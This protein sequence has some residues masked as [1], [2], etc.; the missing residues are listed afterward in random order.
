MFQRVALLLLCL[1]ACGGKRLPTGPGS[2]PDRTDDGWEVASFEDQGLQRSWFDW[3]EHD[4]AEATVETPDAVVVARN[5][6]LVYERYWNGFAREEAHD[7]RSATKSLTSLL[8][9]M[10]HERGIL[11]DLDAPVLSLLPH[12]LPVRNPDPRKERITLRHLLQMRTGLACD[13][14]NPDSPGNEERM[15]DT[16]DWVR[17]IVDVPMQDEPGTVTRYCTGG[18]VLLG[19]ALEHASGR[20]VADL[21]REWLFAP[22]KVQDFTW[23][24]AGK[25]GTDTGGHLRLRPRDFLKTGQVVLEGG[26]WQGER[27]VS[28][29][30]VAESG[31][32]LGALGDAGY[33]LLWWSTRFVIQGVPVEV[34]FAR[35]N[36]GQ[37]VFVAPSLGLTAA[38]TASHYNGA[39]SSLPLDLFGRYVLPAALGLER[40]GPEAAGRK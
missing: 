27:L 19:A 17:F 11:P 22:L 14:W 24:P 3:L 39:G 18:V 35:G 5:G 7:L 29:E 6:R 32:A 15:A 38:F 1:T 37:Y 21:S 20:S 16:G 23:Q 9:G 25:K 28:A 10:A 12:L 33:G 2:P 13:D 34:T 30:W 8:V 40:P 4:V 31:K 26:V 36:G